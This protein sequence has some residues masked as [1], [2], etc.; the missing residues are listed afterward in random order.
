M[1]IKSVARYVRLTPSKARP[2]ARQMKGMSLNE[3]L[4]V[5]RFSTKKAA[6]VIGKVLKTA[7]A[8]LTHNHKRDAEDF[9]VEKIIIEEGP[10]I[11]RYWPRSRGMVRPIRRK[12]SHVHVV[13]NDKKPIK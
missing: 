6:V 1:E 11:K 12:T 7:V 5:T 8:D 3:A 4:G 9:W 10:F 2:F 13:L